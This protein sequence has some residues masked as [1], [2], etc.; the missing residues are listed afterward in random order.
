MRELLPAKRLRGSVGA[1][2]TKDFDDFRSGPAGFRFSAENLE[3][4]QNTSR[5]FYDYPKAIELRA[6]FWGHPLAGRSS[7]HRPSRGEE[8]LFLLPSYQ[9]VSVWSSKSRA[10]VFNRSVSDFYS[11][12]DRSR[13]TTSFRSPPL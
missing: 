4:V 6:Q 1:Q 9:L 3:K 5:W 10:P 12:A 2:A 8:F 7:R 11:S 13:R